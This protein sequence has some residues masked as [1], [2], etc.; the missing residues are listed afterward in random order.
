MW[1]IT[2]GYRDYVREILTGWERIS[3]RDDA[4][5]FTK[6]EAKDFMAKHL[7]TGSIIPA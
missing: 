1:I 2:T 3:W 7:I 4:T 6:Q 5:R